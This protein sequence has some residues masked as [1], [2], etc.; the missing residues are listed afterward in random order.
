MH[1]I[2]AF[3]KEQT[4]WPQMPKSQSQTAAKHTWLY[5]TFVA[6]PDRYTN[7]DNL[8]TFMD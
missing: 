6:T 8:P 1:I 4:M 3:G 7:I 2:I 5:T